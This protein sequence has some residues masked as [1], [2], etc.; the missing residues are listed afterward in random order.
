MLAAGCGAATA[1]HAETAATHAFRASDAPAVSSQPLSGTP[2]QAAAEAKA[3]LGEFVPP[4]GA[5][6]L[7]K[8]PTLPSG[9][10]TMGLV[11]TTTVQAEGYWRVPGDATTLLAWEKAH[12]SRRFSHQDAFIGPPDWSTVYSLPPL[13]GVFA[14]REL[15]AQF[16]D[17]GGGV[18]VIAVEAM[19]A[20]EPPRPAT[21][22]IPAS[23]TVV[24][25]TM[26]APKQA[27]I[28][29]VP[30]VR[31]LAALVNGLPL[32]TVGP[33]PCPGGW[34]FTL[35]FRATA[36]G[37]PVAVVHG[38][39][40]CGVVTFRLNGKDQPDL[41]VLGQASY[42]NAVLKIAGLHWKLP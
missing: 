39:G 13:P 27:T 36:D 25:I 1:P 14:A 42:G 8:Q 28:T 29:S 30:V 4:P 26:A 19:V 38:P 24:T 3:V 35:T 34:G 40:G 32:S 22:V 21:E 18:T 37:P 33:V 23:V 12:M 16:S 15:N 7:A 10:G 5:V 20:W 2:K 9:G 11:Y 17:V 31:Q 41:M 6:R